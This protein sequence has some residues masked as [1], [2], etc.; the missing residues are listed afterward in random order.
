MRFASSLVALAGLTAALAAPSPAAAGKQR[1]AAKRAAALSPAEVL[2]TITSEL[3]STTAQVKA[4]ASG[5]VAALAGTPKAAT[6]GLLGNLLGGLLGGS[7]PT[8]SAVNLDTVTG[9]LGD[10]VGQVTDLQSTLEGLVETG[11]SVTEDLAT[12]SATALK[13]VPL[14]QSHS[15]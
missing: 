11:T 12:V 13:A 14:Q 7:K 1:Q 8:A 15:S 4:T 10:I 3:E 6:G 9:L 2:D 5:V